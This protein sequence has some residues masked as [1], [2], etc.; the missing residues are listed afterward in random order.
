MMKKNK[1][2]GEKME[3]LNQNVITDNIKLIRI[4]EDF[5]EEMLKENLKKIKDKEIE[6]YLS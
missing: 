1:K 4:E 6:D 3:I 5:N 2:I